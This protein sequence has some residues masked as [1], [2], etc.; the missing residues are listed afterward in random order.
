MNIHTFFDTETTGIPV[1]REPSDHQEQPHIVQLAALQ[2]DIDTQKVI[3]SMDVIVRPDAWRIPQECIDVHGITNE[4]A[5][6]IG[7][8]EPVA[9]DMLLALCKDKPRVAFNAPFDKRIGRIATKRYCSEPVMDEWQG[10]EFICVMQMARKVMGGKNPKLTA[11]YE[12][13]TGRP[14][15]DA[16]SALADTQAAFDVYFAIKTEQGDTL[17]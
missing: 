13:F 1:W 10:G 16:H 4:L 12:H 2:V 11:A 15:V 5:M 14:L 6:D 8:P 9:V 17:L 7:I 3:Q